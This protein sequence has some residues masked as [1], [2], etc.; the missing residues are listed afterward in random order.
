MTICIEWLGETLDWYEGCGDDPDIVEVCH[1][2]RFKEALAWAASE[3]GTDGPQPPCQIGLVR[4]R[5]DDE[6]VVDRQWAY[7]E[8]GKLPERFS[9]SGGSE[10]PLVPA[11]YHRELE[12]Y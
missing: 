12:R 11:R 6:G 4:D 3:G 2:D 10:G 9:D 7:I 5:L 1:F 8:D